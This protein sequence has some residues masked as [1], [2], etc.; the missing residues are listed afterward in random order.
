MPMT[1]GLAVVRRETGYGSIQALG[2]FHHLSA[3][4]ELHRGDEEGLLDLVFVTKACV[5]LRE[6][7]YSHPSIKA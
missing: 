2:E 6:V 1:H 4:T 7:F 3:C 5:V